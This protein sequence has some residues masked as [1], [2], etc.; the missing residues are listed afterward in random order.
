MTKEEERKEKKRLY[1]KEWH[2]KNK[3]KRK[4]YLKKNKE[5]IKEKRKEYRE[6]N[7]EKINLNEREYKKTNKGKVNAHTAKR[8]ATKLQATPTWSELDKIKIVYQKAQELGKLTGLEYHV[9]HIVPLQ[10]NNVCGLH[11]W[12]NLQ[13]LEASI[14]ISKSN[15]H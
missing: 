1:N 12:H 9:D 4:E 8:R 14:N 15:N 13:I 5:K 6:K 11:V 2:E 10:G 7:K 3:E